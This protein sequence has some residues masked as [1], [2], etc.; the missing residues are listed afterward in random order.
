MG[1]EADNPNIKWIKRVVIG[2]IFALL[3]VQVITLD[4]FR[5]LKKSEGSRPETPLTQ[6]PAPR[7]EIRADEYLLLKKENERILHSYG[8]VDQRADLI[9]IPIDEAMKRALERGA[10]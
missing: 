3:A 2:A 9:R 5:F 10:K 7:L 4:L 6:V 8:W 1:F